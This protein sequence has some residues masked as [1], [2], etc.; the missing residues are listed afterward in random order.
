MHALWVRASDVHCSTPGLDLA[1]DIALHLFLV[2][3]DPQKTTGGA[4]LNI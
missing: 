1:N 2:I 4:A 3:L